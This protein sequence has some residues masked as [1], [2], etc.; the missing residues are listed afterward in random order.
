[1]HYRV[2]WA[3][4]VR[5]ADHVSHG[6]TRYRRV[7]A[8]LELLGH[9]VPKDFAQKATRPSETPLYLGDRKTYGARSQRLRER[10]VL[11][12]EQLAGSALEPAPIIVGRAPRSVKAILVSNVTAASHFMMVPKARRAPTL[13]LTRSIT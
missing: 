7:A 2:N 11:V 12:S 3:K 13:L 5:F 8:L 9:D 10:I 4:V 1:M 6:R